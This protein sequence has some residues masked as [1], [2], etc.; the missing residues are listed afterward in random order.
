MTK[1][2]ELAPKSCKRCGAIFV[3]KKSTAKYC[4]G[5][6]REAYNMEVRHRRRLLAQIAK[7]DGQVL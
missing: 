3:R 7:V 6:C 2:K 4:S 1:A 5:S